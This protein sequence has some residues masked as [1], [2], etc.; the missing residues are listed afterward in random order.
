MKEGGLK[1]LTESHLKEA[2]RLMMAQFLAVLLEEP[3]RLNG[4]AMFGH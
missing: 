2:M 3:G 4:I 1:F